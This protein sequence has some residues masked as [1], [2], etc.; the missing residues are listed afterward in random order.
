MSK[1]YKLTAGGLDKVVDQKQT[2]LWRFSM[3]RKS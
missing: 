1:Y 2:K 3:T